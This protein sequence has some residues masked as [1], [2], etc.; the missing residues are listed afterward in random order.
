M[1]VK[2]SVRKKPCPFCQKKLQAVSK[3]KWRNNLAR[4]LARTCQAYQ[5]EQ[6]MMFSRLVC[7][8]I[9]RYT[10]FAA[11]N[12]GFGR[13]APSLAPTNR[14]AEVEELERMFQK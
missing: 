9:D 8:I 5:R 2:T 11:Q 10:P 7:H 1:S 4:H 12:P 14:K 13:F 6:I 3:H